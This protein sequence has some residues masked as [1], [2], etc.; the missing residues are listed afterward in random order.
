MCVLPCI[1]DVDLEWVSRELE[2]RIL[3]KRVGCLGG[4]RGDLKELRALNRVL[5]W[6]GGG[7]SRMRQ[8]PVMPSYLCEPLE[9]ELNL[10]L[11]PES[12]AAELS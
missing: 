10:A 3:L 11:R 7:G 8:I 6:K 5:R 12:K 1:S 4:D 2:A 9:I